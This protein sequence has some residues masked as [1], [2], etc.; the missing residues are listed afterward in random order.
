[1]SG[2]LIA[3]PSSGSGKTTITLGLL[4]A[5]RNRGVALAPGKAGPD[6]ID[7][8]FHTAASGAPCVNYDPWAMRPE[9]LRFNAGE[10]AGRDRAFIVEAM[11]GLHDAS[12]DGTGSPADLACVLD[13]AVIMVVDCG[14]MAQSVAALVRGYAGHRADIRVAGVILNK[15]GSDRHEKMLRDALVAIHMPVLG[16]V[17]LDSR[18]KL[19][20][21]HLGLVQ[22]SEH[23]E[24]D[25]F[26]E[27][28]ASRVSG[29]CDLDAILALAGTG[30]PDATAIAGLKPLGQR[31]A[32]AR[33]VAFAFCYEHLLRDWRRQGCD[34]SFFS[35]L[36]DEAPQA[37]ADAVYLPGGYP[38]LHAGALSGARQF[39]AGML[40]AR[41]RDARIFAECGGYMTLGEGLVAADGKRYGMLGLLPLV[42]SFAERKRHLG[43]RRA[44][45]RN[46]SFFDGP[47]MAHEF[48]YATIVS[49]GDADRLFDTVDAAGEIVGP[50]GLQRGCVAGS[51]MHLIDMAVTA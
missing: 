1:M 28:A 15:V 21:R 40:A 8:A 34:I 9:L 24:L 35:P 48:H 10:A 50:A 29:G 11:M 12:V 46:R 27:H 37:E 43:Y 45:P 33:D 32:V 36:A 41:D 42:T 39:H 4:R 30:R 18:M 14:R 2:V 7:P 5:L 38:E 17:R 6:Y 3:A 23:G 51:F 47:L 44:T 22:A 20:E 16:V 26:I 31:I 49:E 13:L 19:P 25:A